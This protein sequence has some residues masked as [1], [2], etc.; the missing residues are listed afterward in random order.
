MKN[1]GTL[2]MEVLHSSKYDT[3]IFAFRAGHLC[4]QIPDRFNHAATAKY[5]R[6]NIFAHAK[7][8]K[9]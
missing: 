2:M 3:N 8:V 1:T 9:V 4:N 6:K 7:Y 5:F